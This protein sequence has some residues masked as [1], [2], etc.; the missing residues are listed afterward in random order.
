MVNWICLKRSLGEVIKAIK[1][2]ALLDVFSAK[3][4]QAWL[5]AFLAKS[6]LLECQRQGEWR[7]DWHGYIFALPNDTNTISWL[8]E[9]IESHSL[10]V[11]LTLCSCLSVSLF[12]THFITLSPQMLSHAHSY[13]TV[14]RCVTLTPVDVV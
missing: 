5:V 13:A 1:V 7:A 6:V 14:H 3:C 9:Q 4:R 2:A 12:C 8:T 10:F 11:S